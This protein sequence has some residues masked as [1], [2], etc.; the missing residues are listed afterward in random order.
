MSRLRQPAPQL[1]AEQACTPSS[2]GLTH[3]QRQLRTASGT[4]AC[5]TAAAAAVR[6]VR[7]PAVPDQAA[8]RE[9]DFMTSDDT[10]A[11]GPHPGWL[12]EPEAP[13]QVPAVLQG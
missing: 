1:L 11:P 7:R 4:A 10:H 5:T 9:R 12:A 3:D 13:P 8:H 6:R 2:L